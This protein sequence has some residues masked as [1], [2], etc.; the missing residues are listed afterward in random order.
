MPLTPIKSM[1]VSRLGVLDEHGT[2]DESLVP[3]LS[4]ER[5][6]AIYRGMVHAREADQRM[7]KLQRQGRIGTFAPSTGQE[8]SVC[9]V[10]A[11][12]TPSDWFV[13]TFRELPGLL[14]RGMPLEA[15][16][17]F[18]NGFE[19]G[20][21]LAEQAG[22]TL[23]IDIIVGSQNLHAVGVAYAL[24]LRKVEDAAVVAFCGDGG[25]SQGD[26][27]E[28]LNFAAVWQAPVVFVVQNNQWAISVPRHK[29]TRA[30]SLAQKAWA[31]EMPGVQVD[32]N[33]VLAVYRA[34]DEALTRARS[35]GGPTLIE[36]VTYRM[37]MHTTA[38]DPT[39]YRTDDEVEGWRSRDP[40][41]RFRA[42]LEGRKLWDA[43]K[44]DALVAEVAAEVE[45]AVKSFEEP[46]KVR[47]DLP[48]DH[49]YATP[50]PYLEE[51]RAEFLAELGKE[52]HHG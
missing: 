41:P 34:A 13:P 20:N 8:A 23:P 51:Q 36:N 32:G 38:D 37:M 26:F 50:H 29:Q 10:T 24:K 9:G 11:A 42:F 49:V 28:A 45:A 16:L 35:G 7:L 33:D 5:F 17:L 52:D 14:M 40:I 3:D 22:N 12:M 18:H 44:E 48:F 19:E 21:L 43:A 1:T 6:I 4:P 39:K 2:V 15:N 30:E 46:R 25:T 27:H 31:Y 47:P